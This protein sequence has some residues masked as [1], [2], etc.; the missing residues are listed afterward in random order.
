MRDIELG[1]GMEVMN[2]LAIP[3]A[4]VEV[5]R[6]LRSA[7]AEE[8]EAAAAAAAAEGAAPAAEGGDAAAPAE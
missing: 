2:P 3:V 4:S 7:E 1:E 5:P 6:A 8:E